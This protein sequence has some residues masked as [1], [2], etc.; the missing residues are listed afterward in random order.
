MALCQHLTCQKKVSYCNTEIHMFLGT[1][2]T[3]Q[4]L[5]RL[6]TDSVTL[7]LNS[8]DH[9]LAQQKASV[10]SHTLYLSARYTWLGQLMLTED[11]FEHG[12]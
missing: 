12:S 4:C 8:L 9:K 11:V 6:M 1:G 3:N 5:T 7:Q 2:M 10:C